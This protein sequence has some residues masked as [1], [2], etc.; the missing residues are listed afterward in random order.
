MSYS[1]LLATS[2]VAVE[3]V[4]ADSMSEGCSWWRSCSNVHKGIGGWHFL[5]WPLRCVDRYRSCL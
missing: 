3:E 4:F 5:Y 2:A 1:E